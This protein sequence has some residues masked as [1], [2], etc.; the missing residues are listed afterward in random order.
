LVRFERCGALVTVGLRDPVAERLGR[1]FEL[2]RQFLRRPTG[3]NQLDHLPACRPLSRRCC[4]WLNLAWGT[5]GA[6]T[7]L[8]PPPDLCKHEPIVTILSKCSGRSGGMALSLESGPDFS[9]KPLPPLAEVGTIFPDYGCLG[10]G[11]EVP[12]ARRALTYA[13]SGKRGSSAN[14]SRRKKHG[15]E[16]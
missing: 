9:A 12:I 4:G 2:L 5:Y 7:K 11:T 13:T 1:R 3:P 16:G 6:L 10:G 14:L 15:T 8:A